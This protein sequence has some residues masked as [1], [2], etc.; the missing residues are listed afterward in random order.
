MLKE[1]KSFESDFLALPAS[2]KELAAADRIE[3]WLRLDNL[4]ALLHYS[5]R[6]QESSIWESSYSVAADTLIS[7]LLD[8]TSP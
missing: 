5:S 3:N 2:Q 8:S 7:S 6:E 4:T 1:T